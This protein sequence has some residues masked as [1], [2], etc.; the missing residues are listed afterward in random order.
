MKVRCLA[1]LVSL[2]L[3]CI[4]SGAQP[5]ERELHWDA[6][7][8]EAHLNADGVL[9]VFFFRHRIAELDLRGRPA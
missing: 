6:L 2:M 1:L 5:A 9:D 8:V 7:Y 4:S 3:S